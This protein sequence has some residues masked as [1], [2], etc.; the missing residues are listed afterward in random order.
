M[1]GPTLHLGAFATFDAMSVF[2]L[3]LAAWLV[4]RAGDRRDATGWMI[5]AGVVLALANATSYSTAI[6]DVI[7]IALALVTAFPGPAESWRSAAA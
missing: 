1:L 5:A 6:F 2:L 7:V 4:V 3:A